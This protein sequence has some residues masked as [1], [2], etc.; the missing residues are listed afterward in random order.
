MVVIWIDLFIIF[1][2]YKINFSI[3]LH[4]LDPRMT[5]MEVK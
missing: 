4:D 5:P 3:L 1:V 2:T